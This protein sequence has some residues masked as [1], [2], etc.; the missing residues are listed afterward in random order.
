M[1]LVAL[2]STLTLVSQWVP[3][4][5]IAVILVVGEEAWDEAGDDGFQGGDAAGYHGEVGFDRGDGVADTVGLVVVIGG[6]APVVDDDTGDGY[7]SY[8]R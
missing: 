4:W 7:G 6:E 5:P 3:G 8:T 2:R 1:V